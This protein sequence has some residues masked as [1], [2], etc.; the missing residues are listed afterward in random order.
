[1]KAPKHSNVLSTHVFGYLGE[2]NL[3]F[4][5]Y[6]HKPCCQDFPEKKF[7]WYTNGWKRF[8][9]WIIKYFHSE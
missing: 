7:A 3:S 4:K 6:A 8:V 1:M 9:R 2:I 5:K